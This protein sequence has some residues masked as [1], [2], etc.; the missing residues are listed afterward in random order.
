[1]K[2]RMPMPANHG[3]YRKRRPDRKKGERLTA[4]KVAV[5][6]YGIRNIFDAMIRGPFLS[7]YEDRMRATQLEYHFRKLCDRFVFGLQHLNMLMQAMAREFSKQQ[8]RPGQMALN[9]QAGYH[10][11][12][13]L[14][15]LSTLVDDIA[16]IIIFATGTGHLKLRKKR[17]ESMGNLKDD[18]I[19]TNPLLASVKPLLDHLLTANSWWDL[20][21]KTEVGARQLLIHNRYLITFQGTCSPGQPYEAQA[22]LHSPFGK[23]NPT[24]FFHQLRAIFADLFDWLDRLEAALITQLRG[25][26][27]GWSPTPHCPFLLLP[28]GGPQGPVVYEQAYFPLPLCDG[29][30]PLPWTENA[31]LS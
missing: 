10:A 7:K 11:D 29:S 23:S 6:R 21:F 5:F 1:M 27:A 14:T 17:I 26:H 24:D 25:A 31:V 30:D 12:H 8:I 15:Y 16:G 2:E 19:R 9:L 20:A 4:A 13:L 3:L 18:S 22:V 28:V